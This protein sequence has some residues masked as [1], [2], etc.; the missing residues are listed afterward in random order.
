ML[1]FVMTNKIIEASQR[2]TETNRNG[3]T[4]LDVP[5]AGEEVNEWVQF[6]SSMQP[7]MGAAFQFIAELVTKNSTPAKV[8]DVAASH[9]MFAIAVA[10]RAPSCEIVALEF[11]TVLEVTS[12]NAKAAGFAITLLP[13]S[14]FTTDL[15]EGYDAALVTNLFHHFSI[16]DNIALM[17]RFHT[18]LRP[19]GKMVILEMV[20]NDDRVT[21]PQAA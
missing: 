21:P 13:G 8:L 14:A 3:Y 1:P 4:A 20:P 15:G 17:K 11:P 7:M 18:A 2:L 6:A 10:R 5:L 19:G 16:E 12:E 9:G